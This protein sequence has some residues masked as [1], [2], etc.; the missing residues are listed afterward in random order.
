MA[1]ATSVTISFDHFANDSTGNPIN[2][3]RLYSLG[4]NQNA[5]VDLLTCTAGAFTT[6]GGDIVATL[7]GPGA[8]TGS[9]PNPW[10]GYSSTL[11]LAAGT[12]QIRFA[13][14]DNRGFFQQG[15]DNVSVTAA[16]PEPPTWAML[17][18]GF[19]LV[20]AAAR[21]RRQILA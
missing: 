20:G 2:N 15:V 7:F 18:G 9:N 17:I 5:V 16:I 3:G 19:G 1:S 12:Y 11:T 8:D 14:A 4:A 6:N 13:Q 21:R 10:A